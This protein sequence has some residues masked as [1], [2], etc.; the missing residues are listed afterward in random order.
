M[1]RCARKKH[2][3]SHLLFA[4][5]HRNCHTLQG[6]D[7]CERHEKPQ[8]ASCLIRATGCRWEAESRLVTSLT[9]ICRSYLSRRV[10][11]DREVGSVFPSWGMSGAQRRVDTGGTGHAGKVG[12]RLAAGLL[13]LLQG[14]CSASSVLKSDPRCP[15]MCFLPVNSMQL[16]E[17]FS[18]GLEIRTFQNCIFRKVIH[19]GLR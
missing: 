16:H 1:L 15:R 12:C 7:Y 5:N 14:T 13:L 6:S 19:Q 17:W 2:A 18:H 4:D 9:V 3:L 8:V 11:T 10:L